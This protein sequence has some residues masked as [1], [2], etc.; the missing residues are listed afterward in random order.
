M[1]RV[2]DRGRKIRCLALDSPQDLFAELARV[3][4]DEAAWDIFREKS[5]VLAIKVADL[6]VAGAN[7]LKQTALKIGADC[8]VDKRVIS[9]KVR[10]SP[11]IIFATPRQIKELCQRLQ[12]QPE[13]AVRI[14]KELQAFLERYEQP[15][16]SLKIGQEVFE[17]GKR[18]YLMG[19]LN[20]TPDSFYDGGRFF[21]PEQAV[22][23]GLKLAEEGADII[24]IGA[25]STRPGSQPVPPEEQ[26]RRLLPVL[27]LL[28]KRVKM[29]ISIDTTN[30][31][32]ARAALDA[33][34]SLVNDISGLTFDPEMARTVARAGV[35]VIVMHIK[36]RPRT[37]QRNPVYKDLMGEI[38][39]RLRRS[40]AI[41][42][43]AGIEPGWMLVDP[44]IGFG[45]TRQHNLEILRRLKE[46]RTLG[47]PIVVGPSRK[48]F[49]G[50]VLN[51]PPAERLEGTIAACVLAAEN[52]ADI[53][54]VHD[55]LP[56]KRALAI[57][58]AIK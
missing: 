10:K 55:V 35:P 24:D 11:A 44:G 46:L 19:V 5:R 51:L 41:G 8:A 49:I 26:L 9:G 6:S 13:C 2:N 36:G 32:V 48:S 4:V 56:V 54:R 14:A 34:A 47:A 38:V 21:T 18:T 22:A 3:G 43:K 33:G 42:T 58:E 20:V 50:M 25:E 29:P 39:S 15:T 52:G 28:A 17:F 23:Q 16:P 30:A 27:R 1:A 37:M 12:S 53:L 45:K 31:R 57:R 40:L 7:I